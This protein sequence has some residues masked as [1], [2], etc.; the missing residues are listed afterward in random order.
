MIVSNEHIYLIK[1]R[2]VDKRKVEGYRL[3]V[4]DGQ[5]ELGEQDLSKAEVIKLAYKGLIVNAK[6][7]V[8]KQSLTG[9]N[10]DF[11]KLPSIDIKSIQKDK[12]TNHQKARN[13]LK[14]L[15]ILGK[16]KVELLFESNDHVRLIRVI[17][18]ESTGR[19][20]VPSFITD[21]ENIK[22]PF[23]GCKFT[24][25]TIDNSPNR[26]FDASCLFGGIE[27][28]NL[29]IKFTHPECIVTTQNMFSACPNLEEV[30]FENFNI[31]YV[32]IMSGMFINCKNLKRVNT[33]D[34]IVR[35]VEYTVY[36]F[37]FCR[38]IKSI[39]ISSWNNTKLKNIG[40]MFGN[41]LSLTSVKLD[42]LDTHNLETCELL[43][44]NC[45]NLRSVDISKWVTPKLRST[46]NMFS[47]CTKL[48]HVQMGNL[49]T[50]S[51]LRANHMFQDC[52]SLKSID[53]SKISF[54]DLEVAAGM[55][56]GCSSIEIIDLSNSD[57]SNLTNADFMFRDCVKLERLKL[58]NIKL[59]VL[60]SLDSTF[61]LC[62]SLK[63]INMQ[64]IDP[65]DIKRYKNKIEKNRIIF[66][67]D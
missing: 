11:R 34:W 64:N 17:D 53:L 31:P 46:E 39:D 32:R 52:K 61:N 41:C 42:G 20:T 15:E 49:D 56:R 63:E 57:L 16:T 62:I 5:T 23:T 30:F 2:I 35:D 58:N 54:K 24:E 7:N 9:I 33:N 27:S 25:I 14:K 21:I 10:C 13:F 40:R 1:A 26:S 29:K 67:F 65:N 22:S 4:Y 3:K 37:D 38:S 50:S 45:I 44:V 55:F 18:N 43:F 19:F 8:S 51:L 47:G 59:S 28:T 6:Y 60:F 48:K 12:L 36:M 66:H